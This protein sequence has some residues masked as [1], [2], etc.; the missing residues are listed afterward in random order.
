MH[1]KQQQAVSHTYV[2]E[3]IQYQQ[4]VQQTVCSSSSEQCSKKQQHY[5]SSSIS[6]AAQAALPIPTANTSTP[7]HYYCTR[8]QFRSSS[9]AAQHYLYAALNRVRQAAAPKASSYSTTTAVAAYCCKVCTIWYVPGTCT[10][11]RAHAQQY[12][13]F[14]LVS[15]CTHYSNSAVMLWLYNNIYAVY[16]CMHVSRT[17]QKCCRFFF[18]NTPADGYKKSFFV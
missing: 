18:F 12:T 8:M 16:I 14:L 3:S 10:S 5:S 7:H 13:E 11:V 6:A 9:I 1:S 2:H 4:P 15:P 17:Y